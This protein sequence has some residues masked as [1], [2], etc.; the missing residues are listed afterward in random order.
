VAPFVTIVVMNSRCL[1]AVALGPLIAL[2]SH[3]LELLIVI[4]DGSFF[5]LRLPDAIE[6][7]LS[8]P[9]F[10]VSEVILVE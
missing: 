7:V 10:G 3:F 8:T 5:S 6:R 9:G 1:A 4:Q 2:G